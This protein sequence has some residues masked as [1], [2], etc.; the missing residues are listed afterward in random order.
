MTPGERSTAT[1]LFGFWARAI[2]SHDGRVDW[3]TA[4]AGA[5]W[6]RYVL[7]GRPSPSWGD[8]IPE[9]SPGIARAWLIRW[10]AEGG[11]V[12][13]GEWARDRNAVGDRRGGAA[14]V[15]AVRRKRRDARDDSAPTPCIL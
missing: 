3:R 7:G 8:H 13:P 5:L 2:P 9:A 14:L 4:D 12:E 11:V 1:H 10:A 6:D 15:A